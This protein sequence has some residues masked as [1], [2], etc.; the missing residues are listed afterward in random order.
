[1]V[2]QLG[3]WRRVAG[4]GEAYG[5]DVNLLGT[6]STPMPH[7]VDNGVRAR[8]L[9]LFSGIDLGVMGSITYTWL[10]PFN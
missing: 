2:S 6:F 8:Q 1:M 10:D 7:V 3:C 4:Y 5:G 9:G